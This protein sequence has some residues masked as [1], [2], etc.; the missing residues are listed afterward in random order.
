MIDALSLSKFHSSR[1]RAREEK[2]NI[3]YVYLYI[4]YSTCTVV[5]VCKVLTGMLYAGAM[6]RSDPTLINSSFLNEL[7]V[8]VDRF[9]LIRMHTKARG[10]YSNFPLRIYCTVLAEGSTSQISDGNIN[11]PRIAIRRHYEYSLYCT[12]HFKV[13]GQENERNVE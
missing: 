3:L 13:A 9:L 10:H 4:Q 12:L 7:Y 8:D 1:V 11:V 6:A 5:H 2:I